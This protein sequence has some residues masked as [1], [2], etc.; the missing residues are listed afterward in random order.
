MTE[1]AQR[2]TE[3]PAWLAARPPV[4]GPHTPSLWFVVCDGDGAGAYATYQRGAWR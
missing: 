3:T 1:T 2:L 4:G